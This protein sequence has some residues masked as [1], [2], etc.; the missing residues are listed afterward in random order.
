MRVFPGT[1]PL[2]VITCYYNPIGYRRRLENYRVFR[3]ELRAPLVTVELSFEHGPQLRPG[4][5][6]VLVH[7]RGGDVLWQTERL[8]NIA[9]GALP[10]TCGHVAWID[11]DMILGRA[12]WV[13]CASG[14][15][16][17]FP[18]VQL[19][20]HLYELPAN[21]SAQ[22]CD[23]ATF[24]AFSF[25]HVSRSDP[26]VLE[27]ENRAVR[28][29]DRMGVPGGAWAG[30]REVLERHGLYDAAILGGGDQGT[31]AAAYGM[32]DRFIDLC[33]MNPHQ[34]QHYLNW[35]K[36][37]HGSVQANVGCVEGPLYHLWHGEFAKRYYRQRHHGLRPFEFD[38]YT[39]I[40]VADN[41][42]WR[43]A[44]DKQA[45]HTFVRNYFAAREEDG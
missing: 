12:D 25:A 2:W 1:A 43:W 32:F 13:A 22:E 37:F 30:R 42:I 15:L 10:P 33:S 28:R 29:G 18:L 3:Q 45:L 23:R 21:A 14:L 44:S 16:E 17:R 35:A 19:F 24:S 41:G 8:F 27:A 26:Q 39:D 6:D 31:T 7:L 4:D 5:A 34:R 38:P 9:L 40:A 36:S 11:C 20:S